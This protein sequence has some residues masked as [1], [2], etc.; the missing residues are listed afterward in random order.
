MLELGSLHPSA[1]ELRPL[2]HGSLELGSLQVSVLKIRELQIQ[3]LRLS[4]PIGSRT[5]AEDSQ[6]SLDISAYA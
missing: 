2:K 3:P 1:L 6:D 4:L 5:S